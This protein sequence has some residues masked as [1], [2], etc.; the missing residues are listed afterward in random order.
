MTVVNNINE[1]NFKI[2]S[3]SQ[4][5]VVNGM[6]TITAQPII[7]NDSCFNQSIVSEIG[8]ITISVKSRSLD[9]VSKIKDLLF[10][11]F[12]M[13]YTVIKSKQEKFA[14]KVGDVL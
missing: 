3:I 7:D 10:S 8:L 5:K 9:K 12:F 11:N 4:S 13:Q 2:I 1:V 6:A 14:I